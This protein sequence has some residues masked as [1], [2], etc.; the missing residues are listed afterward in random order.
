MDVSRGPP[1]PELPAATPPFANPNTNPA[2]AALNKQ[3]QQPHVK[4]E[5]K[6]PADEVNYIQSPPKRGRKPAGIYHIRIY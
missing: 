2:A 4:A 5:T 3:P 6:N 1:T